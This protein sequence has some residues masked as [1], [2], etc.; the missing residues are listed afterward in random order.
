[1]W[2][3]INQLIGKTSK[4]TNVISVK[5]NDQIFTNKDDIAETFNDYFSESG[6]ELSNRI[7][8]G[9]EGFEEYLDRSV[10]AVSEFK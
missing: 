10:S 7:P 5:S 4:T 8:T 2:R 6:T 9:N 3:N 1:M